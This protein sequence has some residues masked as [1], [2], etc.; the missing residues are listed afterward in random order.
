MS[1]MTPATALAY[2][3]LELFRTPTPF[4]SRLSRAHGKFAPSCLSQ[5]STPLDSNVCAPTRIP[6]LP[7]TLNPSVSR[8]LHHIQSTDCDKMPT[9]RGGSHSNHIPSTPISC[10]VLAFDQMLGRVPPSLIP[11]SPLHTYTLSYAL[12]SDP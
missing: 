4:P 2:D 10:R 1:F 8:L 9:D 7:F 6:F 3:Q 11:F 5:V 12:V